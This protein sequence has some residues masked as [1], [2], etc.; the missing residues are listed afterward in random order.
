MKIRNIHHILALMCVTCMFTM[1]QEE[2]VERPNCNILSQSQK[3][4]NSAIMMPAMP[5]PM[6]R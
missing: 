4:L 6:S 3:W 1:C 5:S 2:Y